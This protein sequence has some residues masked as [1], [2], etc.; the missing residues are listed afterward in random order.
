M[1]VRTP[2]ATRVVHGKLLIAENRTFRQP[3]KST[4]FSEFEE[5]KS[6]RHVLDTYDNEIKITS[7]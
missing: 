2:E 7:T 5:F 3:R 6:G 4:P 1:R